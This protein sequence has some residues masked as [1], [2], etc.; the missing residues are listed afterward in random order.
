LIQALMRRSDGRVRVL[1]HRAGVIPDGFPPEVEIYPAELSDA[2]SLRAIC[3]DVTRVVHL[4]GMDQ[5]ACEASPA[6]CLEI[7]GMGTL[8]LAEAAASAGVRRFLFVSTFH[9]YGAIPGLLMQEDMALHPTTPYAV[10]RIAG[11]AFARIAGRRGGMETV[12]LRLANGYGAPTSPLPGAWR[13]AVNDFCRQAVHGGRIVLR[14]SGRQYRDF[15]PMTDIVEAIQHFL[16][17]PGRELGDGVF[18]IGS[19]RL[20][21][22]L[23]VAECVRDVYAGVSGTTPV[24]VQTGSDEGSEPP[25]PQLDVR[26]AAAAGFVPRDDMRGEIRLTLAAAVSQ[27]ERVFDA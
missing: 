5:P 3:T 11:E 6:A 14:R 17:L 22:L 7:S 20:R 19:N 2:E 18:N 4:A 27:A 10:S 15:V 13:L 12:V 8:R 25:M 9:V 16:R 24:P 26:K 21:T 1:A 23:E